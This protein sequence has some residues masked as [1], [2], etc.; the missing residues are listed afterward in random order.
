MLRLRYLRLRAITRDNRFGADLIFL[1]GLNIV[2]VG[3]TSGKSTCLQAIVYALGLERSL[4]PQLQVPLPY[5][6]RE[7]IHRRRDDEY[8]PVLESYV[9]LEIENSSGEILVI[10]RDITGGKDIKLVRTWNSS[11]LS[12]GVERGRERDFSFMTPE[13][14]SARMGFIII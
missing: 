1:N 12:S 13:Q 4:G 10:H 14:L 3:N 11:K 8:E 5:A 6:M 7:R 9:E 2:Q